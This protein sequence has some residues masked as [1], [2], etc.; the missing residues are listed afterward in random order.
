METKARLSRRD[1]EE[2]TFELIN[3]IGVQ[4]YWEIEAL[5]AQGANVNAVT[6]PGDSFPE[7]PLLLKAARRADGDVVQ[8]LIKAGAD[9]LARDVQGWSALHHAATAGNVENCRVLIAAGLSVDE[10]GGP[11]DET[12]IFA[13]IR[14]ES[15]DVFDFLLESGAD[16]DA[17]STLDTTP[18]HYAAAHTQMDMAEVLLRRGVPVSVPAR[19]F[20][21]YSSSL[22]LASAL[23]KITPLHAAVESSSVEACRLLVAHGA[24]PSY[25]PKRHFEKDYLSPV[26][27]AIKNS[28]HDVLR[29]FLFEC[30][31][32]FG[33]RTVGNLKQSLAELAGGDA[34]VVEWLRVAEVERAVGGVI[35][36]A[37]PAMAAEDT[38]DPVGR[39]SPRSHSPGML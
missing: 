35:D 39:L 16:P 38:G 9:I 34:K 36:A 11:R 8:V 28:V 7:A 23:G 24:D 2:K 22:E 29:Y 13:A 18:L 15:R 6:G 30:Q 31:I 10:K 3:A 37:L 19:T 4:K 21:S 14:R 27:M 17:R 32:D 33:Q 5:V 26:Q 12:P 20:G 25:M 1:M